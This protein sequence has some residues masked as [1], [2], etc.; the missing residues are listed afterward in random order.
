MH[1]PPVTRPC[2]FVL[3][4]DDPKAMCGRSD[5]LIHG[6]QCCTSGDTTSPPIDGCSAGCVVIN[7]AEREKLRV[8]D[9]LEV[10]SYESLYE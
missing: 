6:C 5:F 3:S 8:G 1:D 10:V 4:P 7:Q 9:K 2:S